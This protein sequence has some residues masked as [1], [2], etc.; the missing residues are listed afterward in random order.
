[1]YSPFNT[2]MG[3]CKILFLSDKVLDICLFINDA[4]IDGN[5]DNSIKSSL[6]EQKWFRNGIL[7]FFI[8]PYIELNRS[9]RVL[10]YD[11]RDC[12]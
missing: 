10:N 9:V 8:L 4:K 1:M 12:Y 3:Y 5:I 7:F 2:C 11:E 6:I